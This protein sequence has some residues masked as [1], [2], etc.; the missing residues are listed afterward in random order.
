MTGRQL[1]DSRMKTIVAGDMSSNIAR[2]LKDEKRRSWDSTEA[3]QIVTS[4]P[5]RV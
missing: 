1:V 5:F 3:S 2:D 4:T